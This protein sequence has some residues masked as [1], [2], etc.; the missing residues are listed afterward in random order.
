MH[1]EQPRPP[2]PPPLLRPPLPPLPT[3]M[4]ADRVV[5]VAWEQRPP[6]KAGIQLSEEW[7]D[8]QRGAG[9]PPGIS[10]PPRIDTPPA[11]AAAR[12]NEDENDQDAAKMINE[13]DPAHMAFKQRKDARIV[14][15]QGVSSRP[16]RQAALTAST[17]LSEPKLNGKMTQGMRQRKQLKAAK[18]GA[19]EDTWSADAASYM[20]FN[21]TSP[22]KP[23]GD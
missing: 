12:Q 3:E 2:T 4:P 20:A 8:D 16:R 7:F 18:P 14:P 9:T 1:R 15:A 11:A 5:F 6:A 21:K 13:P 23:A 10:S 22:A 19:Y 17:N